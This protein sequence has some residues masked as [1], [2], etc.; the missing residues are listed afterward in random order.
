MLYVLNFQNNGYKL[1]ASILTMSYYLGAMKILSS[2]N[3]KNHKNLMKH[4]GDLVYAR[5]IY[6][7]G[8]NRNLIHLL[9]SRYS[10]MN[11]FIDETMVGI[12]VG[13][14]IGASKD[15]IKAKSFLTSDFNAYSWIDLKNVDAL[16]TPFPN[17]SLDFVV[18]S[19]MIHHLSNPTLFLIEVK[20]ILRP[21]GYLLIQE[22]HTSLL[23][24]LV[25]RL[26]R[27]EGYN[28]L[29]NVFDKNLVCSDPNDPWSANNSI[30]KLLF[31]KEQFE[32]NFS[33]WTIIFDKKVEFLSF[34]NS[35]GVTAKTFYVPLPVLILRNLYRLD[36]ILIKFLPEFFAFQRQIVIQKSLN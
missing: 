32:K 25:L 22:V 30:P 35:G 29:V 6:L 21:G 14:G 18:S 9:E 34:L 36:S 33:G 19:N 12:E 17:D 2:Y 15:F 23:M 8:K 13:S 27:H 16:A 31:R 11:R 4:E 20:R 7:E 3:G 1:L 10:W 24:R 28:E 5:K 26:M